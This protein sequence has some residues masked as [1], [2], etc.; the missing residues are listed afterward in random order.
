[1]SRYRKLTTAC[2]AA[3]LALGLAA[4]GSS[5]ST[6]A[7]PG[8]GDDGKPSPVSLAGVPNHGLTAQTVTIEAGATK[9][10]GNV[11]FSCPSGGAD[12]TVAITVTAGTATVTSDGG[13]ATAAYS[14]AYVNARTA[15]A[16]KMAKS[17]LDAINAEVSQTT[18]AGLGGTATDGSA[19]TTYSLAVTRDSDGTEVKIADTAMAGDDDPKF[20]Q[21]KDLGS[22]TT[23][24][25]R[26]NSDDADG[27]VEEVVVVSTDIDA[28]KAVAFAKFKDMA[29]TTTQALNVM[30]DDGETPGG[31]ETANAFGITAFS[32]TVNANLM[33]AR[34]TTNGTLNYDRDNPGTEPT[35]DVDEGLH[36]GTYNGAEGTYRCTLDSGSCTVTF[37]AKGQVTGVVDGWV[38]IPDQGA[39]SDQPDYNYLSYGFW[40]KKTTKDGETTYDE[41]EA[42]A[43]GIYGT[44]NDG[45]DGTELNTVEGS[46]TY[47]GG[48][49]GVY[50]HNVL[51]SGGGTVA[52][53]TSGLF[54]ADASLTAYFSGG[55][56]GSDKHNTITG[57]I[58]NFVLE[59]GEA[60]D[61]SVALKGT[62]AA[63]ANTVTGTANGGGTEGEFSGI[64]HGPTPEYDHDNDPD[65]AMRRRAPGSVAGEFNANFSNGSVLGAFG[66]NKK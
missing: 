46:A 18:D 64:F 28:P 59:H 38:F 37:N 6:K 39:T 36:D 48:A 2:L 43:M 5:S 16:N 42:F 10:V 29:G 30:K 21:T 53:R 60:Q 54:R 15:A 41:V 27:K 61:W 66:A 20:A 62:R 24:H 44:D 12:C 13:M 40:L 31:N 58:N 35:A 55:S 4:C 47:E 25:V 33:F 56:I 50:V 8:G 57:T 7:P 34:S 17:K 1:M 49:T 11:T 45:S 9:T 26:V 23:M 22:G 63:G 32:G 51:S 65:T 19:V 52:S 3:A 14:S